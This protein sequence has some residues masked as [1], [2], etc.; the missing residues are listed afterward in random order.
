MA[1]VVLH[2]LNSKI[3]YDSGAHLHR[4]QVIDRLKSKET[5]CSNPLQNFGPIKILFWWSRVP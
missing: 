1:V 5:D 3:P 2:L 4:S